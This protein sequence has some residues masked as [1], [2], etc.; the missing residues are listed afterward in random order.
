MTRRISDRLRSASFTAILVALLAALLG[1]CGLRPV[2]APQRLEGRTVDVDALLAATP[3][4]LEGPE[5]LVPLVADA[6]AARGLDVADG[7]GGDAGMAHASIRLAV[8]DDRFGFRRD[9]A[10]TRASVALR[11]D[12]L[13][14]SSLTASPI[15]SQQLTARSF[16]DIVRSDFANDV[17]HDQ[18]AREAAD[19]LAERILVMLT[20]RL[21]RVANITGE[22]VARQAPAGTRPQ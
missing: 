4:H 8:A 14:Y 2:H 22:G 3:L 1:G 15:F 21:P 10:A 16:Y 7:S 20:R 19:A 12:V 18:A 17:R 9:R 13:L 6:L 5:Q 11:A